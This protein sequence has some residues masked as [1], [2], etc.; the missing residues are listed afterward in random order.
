LKNITFH[1]P[2]KERE[3]GIIKTKENKE[4]EERLYT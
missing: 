1:T 4:G 3:Y 2:N